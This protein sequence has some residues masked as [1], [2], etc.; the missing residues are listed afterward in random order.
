MSFAALL[1]TRGVS[2]PE[3]GLESTCI[4]LSKLTLNSFYLSSE[5]DQCSICT[6]PTGHETKPTCP[7]EQEHQTD[8]NPLGP[9]QL[10]TLSDFIPASQKSDNT[11]FRKRLSFFAFQ[12]RLVQGWSKV[13]L[14]E[15]LVAHWTNGFI[16]ITAA[17]ACWNK[18]FKVKDV[19]KCATFCSTYAHAAIS[20]S[21]TCAEP[22]PRCAKTN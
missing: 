22:T 14:S 8:A 1:R 5:L 21:K 10:L 17:H 9:N 12:Y 13:R 19:R 20:L 16:L 15:S 4:T 18:V 3:P 11:F 7:T 6:C 2:C